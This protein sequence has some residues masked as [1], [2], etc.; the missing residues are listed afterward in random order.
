MGAPIADFIVA[1]NTNDIITRFVNDGDMTVREVVPT[2]S[3]SMDIQVSSNFERLLFEIN[4]RDGGL[5]AEQLQ[6]FRA[7][8]RLDLEPD[9]RAEWI[10]GSFRAASCDDNAT[11]YEIARVQ[12]ETGLFI[13][14]HTATATAAARSLGS[15]HPIVTLATAHPAKF[16]DAVERATGVRPHAAGAPRRP[17][18]ADGAHGHAPRRPGGRRAVR[19][20]GRPAMSGSRPID[21]T[22]VI[23]IVRRVP[24]WHDAD[25]LITPLDGGITNRNF[26]IEID[27]AAFVVRLPGERTELLGHRSGRRSRG[28]RPRRRSRHRPAH[29]GR[30]PG[31]RHA[32]HGVRRRQAGHDRGA[33]RARSPRTRDRVHPAACTRPGRSPPRFPIFRVVEWHARDAAANGVD[34]PAVYDELHEAASAIEA[35]FDPR[36]LESTL[37]HN[38]LLPANVLL[39]PERLWIIDYEYAGMNHAV[40]DLANLSVN[41][42]FD[43]AA[44]HRLLMAY[45]GDTSVQ[46]LA[47]LAL[48]K[49]MSEMREGMWAVVQQAISTLTH[50]DF[51]EYAATR[52]GPLPRAVR[53]S[54]VRDVARTGAPPLT[55]RGVS[56]AVY[57]PLGCVTVPES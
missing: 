23:D 36:S 2:L 7:K 16:P 9:Q 19:R 21:E 1:S 5:T 15:D 22:P 8:G 18:R 44:D 53:R 33:A 3:P 34:P 28:V 37:C 49:V 14:P 39:A 56:A 25:P 13:D 55:S 41:C 20:V 48:M 4:G 32:R 54:A 30:A 51:V 35:V 50:V 6:R 47:Q 11:L 43:E 46:R 29:Q 10:A 27:G 40:F 38:D 31:R 24:G 52:L 12:R 57:V 45:D 26:R 42:D 17:A